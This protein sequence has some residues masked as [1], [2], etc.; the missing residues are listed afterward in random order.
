MLFS[1]VLQH[2]KNTTVVRKAWAGVDFATVDD[3]TLICKVY[4]ERGRLDLYYPRESQLTLAL[5]KARYRLEAR[6][7]LR[8]LLPAGAPAEGQGCG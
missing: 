2:G 4:A 5:L 8:M 7:A 6:E 1:V 3:R